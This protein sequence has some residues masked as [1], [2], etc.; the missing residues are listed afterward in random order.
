M[1]FIDRQDRRCEAH[2][3]EHEDGE[4]GGYAAHTKSIA[5]PTKK[6]TY[7]PRSV[8]HEPLFII[9]YQPVTW[10]L[11]RHP[12]FGQGDS[13]NAAHGAWPWSRR[14]RLAKAALGFW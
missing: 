5:E 3:K 7:A 9:Q 10:S 1:G 4:Y 12:R 13:E 14:L 11:K 8:G 6:S 2:Q